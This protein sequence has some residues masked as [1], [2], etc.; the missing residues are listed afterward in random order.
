MKALIDGD[1]VCYRAA[2]SAQNEEP[3]IACSR[4]DKTIQDIL[5]GTGADSYSVFLTGDNNFRR[6]I[7]PEYKANRTVERPTHWVSV[8]EFL[9]AEHR[10]EIIH[11]KEADDALG[12]AQD[13][14]GICTC[15]ASIDKDLKQIPGKHY[16]FV[17]K[18]YS[19]V[20]WTEGIRFLYLQSLIGD[21]SDNIRGVDGI[22]PV[23]AAKALEGLSTEWEYY[24][25]CLELYG[26]EAR[27]HLNMK[28]LYI[29][30]KENDEWRPPVILTS[31][32]VDLSSLSIDKS[33]DMVNMGM[34]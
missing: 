34:S 6:K 10:A 24:N 26:D 7:D 17:K 2:C 5:E 12:I 23:K 4:A 30:Q 19:V 32:M 14:F 20:T 22:G 25:K 33:S 16:N 1:I 8:R 18:E 3:W 31:S 13:K 27:L 15:I 11:G 28:L 9:V 29:W 21:R